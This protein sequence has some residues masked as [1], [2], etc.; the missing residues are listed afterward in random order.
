MHAAAAGGHLGM[1]QALQAAPLSK[2]LMEQAGLTDAVSQSWLPLEKLPLHGP[3]TSKF[4]AW[5]AQCAASCE[6]GLMAVCGQYALF[7][8]L[9]RPGP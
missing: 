6:C 3:V 2:T 9:L 5:H 1:V 7:P 4:G 8:A